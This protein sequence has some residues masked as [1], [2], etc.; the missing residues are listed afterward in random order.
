MRLR[1]DKHKLTASVFF[2][3]VIAASPSWSQGARGNPIGGGS[4]DPVFAAWF[5][6]LVIG[7]PTL[8]AIYGLFFGNRDEKRQSGS[9]FAAVFKG[10]IYFLGLPALAHFIFG[11]ESAIVVFFGLLLLFL[12][13]SPISE[14]V[15]GED[16]DE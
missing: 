5:W 4:D 7:L 14:W 11:G 6:G 9:Y 2:S 12:F 10:L 3:L 1:K 8:A 16:K 13:Y 15:V